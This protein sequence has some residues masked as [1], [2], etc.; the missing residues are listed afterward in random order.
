MGLGCLGENS[1]WSSWSFRY[2]G[3]QVPS[4][5][6]IQDT[7]GYKGEKALT[8]AEGVG[9]GL[10]GSAE[11]SSRNKN[12]AIARAKELMPRRPTVLSQVA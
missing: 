9:N 11:E 10:G 4:E 5:R 6:E 1:R 12:S 7:L 8:G 3:R 2:P